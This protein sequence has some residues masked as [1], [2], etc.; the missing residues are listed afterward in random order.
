MIVKVNRG[1]TV[2]VHRQH[3]SVTIHCRT[4]FAK[5]DEIVDGVVIIL[6]GHDAK[7]IFVI[8]MVFG[9]FQ[10]VCDPCDRK[11]LLNQ[12]RLFLHMFDGVNDACCLHL[13][14]GIPHELRPACLHAG[15]HGE[16][17][18]QVKGLQFRCAPPGDDG[19]HCVRTAKFGKDVLRLVSSEAVDDTQRL[20]A[21]GVLLLNFL[22][23]LDHEL[24]VHPGFF[25]HGDDVVRR[26]CQL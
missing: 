17:N 22:D 7:Q 26:R 13:G 5:S 15:F 11:T 14:G 4:F 1:W 9:P 6:L 8:V 21:L 16:V 20:T 10:C 18:A 12:L 25:L 24:L 23:P 3:C 2:I 19:N